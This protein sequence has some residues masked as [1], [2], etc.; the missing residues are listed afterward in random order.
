MDTFDRDLDGDEDE[1]DQLSLN[2]ENEIQDTEELICD[3]C[4]NFFR[5]SKLKRRSLKTSCNTCVRESR[6]L[7]KASVT[8]SISSLKSLPSMKGF[9]EQD[10]KNNE[11]MTTIQ[12]KEN[13]KKSYSCS[14]C[15]LTFT[16]K[17][18]KAVH[19][20]L[21]KGCKG[22]KCDECGDIFQTFQTLQYHKSKHTG[23]FAYHCSSCGKGFNNF[24]LMEEHS[25][26]HTG[27]RP[28]ACQECD[29]SFANRGSLWLHRKKHEVKKPYVCDYCGKEFGHSSHL[30]VHKRMHTG[31]TPYKCRFCNEGFI[32]G[33]HL[34]RHMKTLHKNELPFACGICKLEFGKR[35]DLVRHGNSVHNGMVVDDVSSGSKLTEKISDPIVETPNL[36]SESSSPK[37]FADPAKV[38]ASDKSDEGKVELENQQPRAE[39]LIK[40][41]L[42]DQ[43]PILLN[44]LEEATDYVIPVS[45]IDDGDPSLKDGSP[46]M[47]QQTFVFIQIPPGRDCDFITEQQPSSSKS[48]EPF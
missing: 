2:K 31:E 40:N 7:N 33:N 21:H 26:I 47:D 23:E 10:L 4:G 29:K 43:E 20:R 6:N 12:Q 28:Y 9:K 36:Q 24:K 17:H 37:Q 14:E 38:T 48:Q 1:G 44:K 42:G 18:N 35:S 25:H 19:A 39:E 32:S 27:D 11:K 3:K 30:V 45:L 8:S 13:P 46:R 16:S 15:P 22:L 41:M 34:K 5:V